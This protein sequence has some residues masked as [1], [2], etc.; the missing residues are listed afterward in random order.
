LLKP[1]LHHSPS[2]PNPSHSSASLQPPPQPIVHA[3]QALNEL[4]NPIK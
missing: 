2:H 4:S 3:L 1:K